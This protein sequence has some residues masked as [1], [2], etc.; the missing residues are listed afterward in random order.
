MNLS[1]EGPRQAVVN[2][3]ESPGDILVREFQT[4]QLLD[5]GLGGGDKNG[6]A[7]GQY[8]KERQRL[9]V[10]T[11][12]K[13]LLRMNIKAGADANKVAET[14]DDILY[15]LAQGDI[16]RYQDLNT[17]DKRLRMLFSRLMKRKLRRGESK[18]QDQRGTAKMNNTEME[19]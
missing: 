13:R 9:L 5:P 4:L 14:I 3:E 6:T 15:R 1:N 11:L 2:A 17:L 18:R 10:E 16:E 7:A 19:L 12:T 8:K